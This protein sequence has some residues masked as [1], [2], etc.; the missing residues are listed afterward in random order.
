M[1][2]QQKLTSSSYPCLRLDLTFV[3]SQ[4]R[5]ATDIESVRSTDSTNYYQKSI[6]RRILKYEHHMMVLHEEFRDMPPAKNP[7]RE[8]ADI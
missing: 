4:V 5:E 3:P 8:P 6:C 7:R 2:H 1:W